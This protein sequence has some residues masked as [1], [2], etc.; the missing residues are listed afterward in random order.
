MIILFPMFFLT[1]VETM[2]QVSTYSHNYIRYNEN[3]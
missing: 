1:C 3:E 2:V